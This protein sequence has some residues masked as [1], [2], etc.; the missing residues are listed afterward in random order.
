L[1]DQKTKPGFIT[2]GRDRSNQPPLVDCQPSVALQDAGEANAGFLET[3]WQKEDHQARRCS[4]SSVS[5][6]K[7]AGRAG[8]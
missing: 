6:V 1:A 4:I 7:V 2:E 3:S 8:E 5:T